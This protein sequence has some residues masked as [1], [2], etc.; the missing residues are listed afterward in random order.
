MFD[1]KKTMTPRSNAEAVGLLVSPALYAAYRVADN[2][3]R[4]EAREVAEEVVE[5]A[6]KDTS[7]TGPRAASTKAA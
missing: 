7:K 5:A 3:I 1:L 4:S 2:F 6:V